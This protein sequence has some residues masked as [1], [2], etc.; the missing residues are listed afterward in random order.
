MPP[1]DLRSD[2]SRCT[3]L[4]CVAL[5]FSRSASFAFDKAAGERCRHLDDAFACRVHDRLGP[6][7]MPGCS[8][9]ECFGA[10]QQVTQVTYGGR[11]WR[12]E[13][14][15]APDVFAVFGVLRQVHE[16]LWLL[17]E[18]AG[19]GATT[20]PVAVPLRELAG[21]AP[22]VVL[23]ADVDG[24]RARVG[25]LLRRTS[26][27]VRRPA[28]PDLARADLVGADLRRRDL[29]AADLRGA[30]LVGADVRGVAL[31]GADLLG[32]DLRGADL[33]GADLS[34]ALFL[35]P[36]QVAAARTDD[37]TRVP[38]RLARTP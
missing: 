33:R 3:G 23:A 34:A 32:A 9:F 10:G 26:A 11:D 15:A 6:L 36:P 21:A 2:C 17:E 25:D 14:G 16:M 28:G 27:S 24:W 18:A 30:L 1:L 7:G 29:A 35:T 5:P 4:C 20:D 8:V 31:A 38:A 12:T 37:G 22:D 19:L 13:P